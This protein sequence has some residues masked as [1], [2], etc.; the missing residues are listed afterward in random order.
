MKRI[1]AI[2][3]SLLTVTV[4][5]CSCGGKGKITVKDGEGKTIAT[6][7]YF[8]DSAGLEKA[9]GKKWFVNAC[10]KEAAKAIAEE[11]K[12]SIEQS[13]DY[14]AENY[15]V[16]Q[17]EFDED[18]YSAIEAAF[19]KN[20]LDSVEYACA[21]TNAEGAVKAIFNNTSKSVDNTEELKNPYSSI[22]PLSVYAPALEAKIINWS[23]V[24]KDSEYKKIRNENGKL[25]SW[26]IN[27]TNTYENK[28]VTVEYGLKKSLNTVAVKCL[29]ELGV[30]NSLAFLGSKL[31]IDVT[32]EAAKAQTYGQDEVIGN[33][34]LGYLATGVSVLDM[35]GYYGIFLNDGNYTKPYF[36]KNIS[37]SSGEVIYTKKAQKTQIIS[38]ETAYIMNNLLRRVVTPEATGADAAVEGLE[39]AGKTGTGNENDG[40]WFVGF[41]PNYCCAVWHGAQSNTNSSDEI[42][43]EIFSNI[44]QKNTRF[45]TYAG[46]K[47]AAYCAVSGKLLSSG[48]TKMEIGLFTEDNMPDRCD[49]H[50]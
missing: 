45:K 43:S 29:A 23:S 17:T 31:G 46:V 9:G 19:N 33:I 34:A 5:F 50:G 4:L 27:A 38:G 26:P 15:C 25:Y 22:K 35:A 21:L 41:S 2:L 28:D 20:I 1:L 42:F 24:F 3:L 44:K 30:N 40:N 6:L 36:V 16:L 7:T 39:V 11:K 12:L 37:D 8:S 13:Q 10:L 48:C 49:L 14:L 47:Q 32:K 18:C